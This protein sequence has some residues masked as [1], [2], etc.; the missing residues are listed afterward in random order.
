MTSVLEGIIDQ[1]ERRTWVLYEYLEGYG[2]AR[3]RSCRHVLEP[4]QRAERQGQ[5]VA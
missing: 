5:R 4:G 1:A 2:T 3:R